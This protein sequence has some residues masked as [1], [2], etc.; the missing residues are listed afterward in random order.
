M[1]IHLRRV[2]A[3]V[4]SEPVALAAADRSHRVPAS[5]SPATYDSLRRSAVSFRYTLP[6]MPSHRSRVAAGGAQRAGCPGR[7]QSRSRGVPA[8]VSPP[9]E[10][11]EPVA[12]AAADRSHRVSASASP[13]TYDSLRRSAVSFRYTLP[14][15]PIHLR[16]VA[17]VVRSEP[18]AMAAADR[19]RRVPA[20]VSPPVNLRSP[21]PVGCIF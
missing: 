19:S 2:A 13:A 20:A 18:V 9:V 5:A 4:R 10:R 3:V 15:M 21:S 7:R 11:S 14:L 16:R 12:L 6:L 8:A 17:A 1:P